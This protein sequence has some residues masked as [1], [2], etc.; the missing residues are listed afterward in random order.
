MAITPLQPNDTWGETR[1]KI[2][3]NDS[4]VDGRLTTLRGDFDN[5]DMFA[6]GCPV[7]VFRVPQDTDIDTLTQTGYYVGQFVNLPPEFNLWGFVQNLRYADKVAQFVMS[8]TETS[9]AII[10]YRNLYNGT[11]QPWLLLT[12]ATIQDINQR[13]ADIESRLDAAGL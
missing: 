5:Q 7:E 12:T 11:W 8:Y 1:T 13:L 2:N 4:D 9:G 3:G 10:A 6:G